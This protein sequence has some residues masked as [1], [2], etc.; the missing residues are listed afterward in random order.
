MALLLYSARR[1]LLNDNKACGSYLGSDY[2][3][4][5]IDLIRAKVSGSGAYLK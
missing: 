4:F 1:V 3:L 5:W 2:H